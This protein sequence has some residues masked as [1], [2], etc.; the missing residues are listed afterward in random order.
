[1]C[2][3]RYTTAIEYTHP[4]N[5][6]RIEA[7]SP[8]HHHHPGPENQQRLRMHVQSIYH[9]LV[10]DGRI[11]PT[12]GAPTPPLTYSCAATL[13]LCS[14]RSICPRSSFRSTAAA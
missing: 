4:P 2:L 6:N 5:P 10:L 13:R 11:S 7:C 1:M 8:H 3:L 9:G 14:S 12:A